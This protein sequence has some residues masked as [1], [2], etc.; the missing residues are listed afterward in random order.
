MNINQRYNMNHGPISEHYLNKMNRTIENSLKEHPRT[1]A[2]R[3]DLRLP[4]GVTAATD[5]ALISRFVGSLKAKLIADLKRKTKKGIRVHPCTLR[6]IW[7]REFNKGEDKKHYHIVLLFNKDTYAFLGNYKANE[8]N[9]ASMIIKA[10]CSAL[11]IDYRSY[12][13]LIHFPENPCYYISRSKAQST[14][15]IG[16][17]IYRASYLAKLQSKSYDDGERNFGCSQA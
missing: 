11:R 15:A 5:S 2:V 4:D 14:D 1:M 8:R 3:V 6:Y 13:Q 12:R 16:N 9:L 10:W 7:V 17:L